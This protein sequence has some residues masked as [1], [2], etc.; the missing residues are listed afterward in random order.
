[1]TTEAPT[2]PT[3]VSVP[4]FGTIPVSEMFKPT[5]PNK[6][7]AAKQ[8]ENDRFDAFL[9]S[10]PAGRA[11]IVKLT[12]GGPSARTVMGLI[13]YALKRTSLTGKTVHNTVKHQ[14]EVQIGE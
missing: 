11:G 5:Y 1:M 13:R 7:S 2:K 6:I 14:V 12:E 9:K 4:E 3:N 8:A 10:I